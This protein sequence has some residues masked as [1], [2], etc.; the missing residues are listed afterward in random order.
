[1]S[2]NLPPRHTQWDG[3]HP[4]LLK[5]LELAASG[6]AQR[7]DLIAAERDRKRRQYAAKFKFLRARLPNPAMAR[8]V[9]EARGPCPSFEYRLHFFYDDPAAGRV[10]ISPWH[11]LPLKRRRGRPRR[12]GSV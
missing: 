9:T 5:E 1:M 8:V 2:D 7:L 3:S 4:S 11:D 6:G 10:E 12:R